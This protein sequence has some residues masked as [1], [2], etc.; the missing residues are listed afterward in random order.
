MF[1]MENNSPTDGHGWPNPNRLLR[2]DT[3]GQKAV[4][5]A[6]CVIFCI[7]AKC[8]RSVAI[9][10]EL[11]QIL[12]YYHAK[13]VHP[14]AVADEIIAQMGWISQTKPRRGDHEEDNG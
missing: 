7:A 3:D 5:Y 13:R 2:Y 11:G 9:S 1:D 4:A 10:E 8:S 14:E 12:A 6:E